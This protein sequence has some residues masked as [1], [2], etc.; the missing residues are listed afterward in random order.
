MSLDALLAIVGLAALASVIVFLISRPGSKRRSEMN[1]LLNRSSHRGRDAPIH[2]VFVSYR[3]ADSADIVGR[4]YDHLAAEHGVNAVFKDVDSIIVGGDFRAQLEQ[5]LNACR[6]FICVMGDQWA[7]PAGS[8]NRS[9]DDPKD[10]VRI[11]VETALRRGIPIIPTFVRGFSMPPKEFFP[12]ALARLA[13]RQGLALRSD[14]DFRGDVAR[15][16]SSVA[17]H[18]E[19]DQ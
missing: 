3:R 10:F 7:G 9:I 1:E 16:T 4:L 8:T 14:P 11:E 13:D 2:S 5:S 15:L 12:E 19:G 18:L 17:R 6:V